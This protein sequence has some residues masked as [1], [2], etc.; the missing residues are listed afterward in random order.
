MARF[1][2]ILAF[3]VCA[4]P[5]SDVRTW[6]VMR[7]GHRMNYSNR[8]VECVYGSCLMH[9]PCLG[10]SPGVTLAVLSG[11]LPLPKSELGFR[12]YIYNPSGI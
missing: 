7:S 1:C 3:G 11:I 8:Q 4:Y 2:Q 10:K 5:V 6:V 9:K 12:A